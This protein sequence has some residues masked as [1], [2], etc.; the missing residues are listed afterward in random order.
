MKKRFTPVVSEPQRRKSAARCINPN[1]VLADASPNGQR[2]V[3]MPH[4]REA[5]IAARIQGRLNNGL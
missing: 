5:D 3:A 4:Q 2:W 1:R